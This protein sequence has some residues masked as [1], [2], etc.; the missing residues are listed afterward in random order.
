V[1]AEALLAA[2]CRSFSDGSYCVF[3]FSGD[4]KHYFSVLRSQAWVLGLSESGV[5]AG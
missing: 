5:C 2:R 4:K 3:A 1:E